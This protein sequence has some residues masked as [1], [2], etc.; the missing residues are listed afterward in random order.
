MDKDLIGS[1]KQRRRFRI[2]VVPL[3][4]VTLILSLFIINPFEDWGLIYEARTVRQALAD[5]GWY[6]AMG[7]VITECSLLVSRLLEPVLPWER[8]PG[9]RFLMQLLLQIAGV[10]VLVSLVI[11]IPMLLEIDDPTMTSDDWLGLQQIFFISIVLSLITTAI[12]TGNYLIAKWR[13]SVLEPARLKQANLQAQLQSLKAQLDPHFMFNNFSTLSNLISENQQDA[14]LFLDRLSNVYRYMASNLSLNIISLKEEMAFIDA[15]IYL[16]KIRF[17]ENL[18]IRVNIPEQYHNKGIPPIT[19]QLLIENAA[20][21]NVASRTNPLHIDITVTD[22]GRLMISNNLQRVRYVIPS[23]GIGIRNITNRNRLLSAEIPEIIETET[24]F[25]IK[26]PLLSINHDLNE[27][28]D[29][30][31]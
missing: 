8:S 26:V 22:D 13:A 15:Y 31:R 16:I 18:E 1:K 21:H 23:A 20:K 5:L 7:W 27:S 9:R 2:I 25:I 4:T 24:M 19:L 17:A 11:F 12:F 30:R 14:L 29:H 28:T 10:M 6:M 3:I